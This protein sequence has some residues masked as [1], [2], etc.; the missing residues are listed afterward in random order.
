MKVEALGATNHAVVG[1]C[2]LKEQVYHQENA[3]NEKK[4][5]CSMLQPLCTP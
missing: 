4:A 2:D 1:V 3:E 5:G